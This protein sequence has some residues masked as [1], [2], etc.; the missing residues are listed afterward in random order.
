MSDALRKYVYDN[1]GFVA[2]MI[3]RLERA[4]RDWSLATDC[5]WHAQMRHAV[6]GGSTDKDF[7]GLCSVGP[8]R[9]RI[10]EDGLEAKHAGFREPA[11]VIAGLSFPRSASDP[12]DAA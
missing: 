2:Q 9:Q 11:L 12:T 10:A 8:S 3:F 5:V 6:E 7:R 4:L 1:N